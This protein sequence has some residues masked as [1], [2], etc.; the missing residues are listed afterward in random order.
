MVMVH[1]SGVQG[2]QN[3][4]SDIMKGYMILEKGKKAKTWRSM[5]PKQE[6][7]RTQAIRAVKALRNAFGDKFM[8]KM[9]KR[10][11]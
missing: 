2:G 7:T 8:Y 6:I 9:V 4:K 1:L 10:K 11:R 3:G 5:Y